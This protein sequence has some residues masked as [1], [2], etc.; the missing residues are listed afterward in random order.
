MSAL[1]PL[2]SVARFA[3]R[4]TVFQS[5]R[6]LAQAAAAAA[7]RLDRPSSYKVVVVGGGSAGLAVASTLSET[8]GKNAVAVVE[9]ADVHYY[10]PLWT[11][12]GSGLKTLDESKRAMKEVMPENAQWI[13]DSVA[14]FNPDKNA[15]V[16]ANGEA[17]TYD[18]LVVA[19]G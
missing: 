13:K 12:V 14:S 8:L 11:F 6:F 5:K 9:P 17:I 18:Y 16:L 3:T 19:A 2:T 7:P 15:V 4:S 10:Q 1:S